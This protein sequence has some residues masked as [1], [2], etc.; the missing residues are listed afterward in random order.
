MTSISDRQTLIVRTGEHTMSTF[1]TRGLLVALAVSL[2]TGAT[3]SGA[4]PAPCQVLPAEA[5]SGIMGYVATATP[6]EMNCTY[7]GPGKT[8]G[9]QFR[10]MA[11]VGSSA[12]AEASVKRMRDHQDHQPK[13]GHNPK[14]GVIDSQ[15]TVVF[16]IALFQR[17]V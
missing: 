4:S 14:L 12:A 1:E 16:S 6:G 8:S 7:Q 3:A 9:G 15:G 11:I 10:I 5:W 2:L 13:G 17:D